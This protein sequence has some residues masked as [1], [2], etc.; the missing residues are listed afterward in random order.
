MS[1]KEQNRT[2]QYLVFRLAGDLYAIEVSRIQEVLE[3]QNIT[4]VP[5]TPAFMLGVINVRGGVIPVVDLRIKF[6]LEV[7]EVT[8]DTC[9]VVL[10][11]PLQEDTVVIGIIADA[12]DEV[13]TLPPEEIETTPSVGTSLDTRFIEGIGKLREHFVI[14]LQVEHIFT[15]EDIQSVDETVT[16]EEQSEG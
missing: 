15:A 8:V 4:K 1:A 10:E 3:Y 9:I 7:T 5:K 2:D 11:I 12:V 13:V 16:R 14:I 6:E